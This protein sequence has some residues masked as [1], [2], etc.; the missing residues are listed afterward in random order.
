MDGGAIA[1]IVIFAVILAVC[2]SIYVYSFFVD[3]RRAYDDWGQ[4]IIQPGEKYP[5]MEPPTRW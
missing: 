3:Y 5:D 2:F 4:Y 1:A